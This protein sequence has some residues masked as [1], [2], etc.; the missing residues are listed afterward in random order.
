MV[1]NDLIQD[2]VNKID[3]A[4][5]QLSEDLPDSSKVLLDEVLAGNLSNIESDSIYTLIPDLEVNKR[6]HFFTSKARL[7]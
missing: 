7:C 6:L 5:E 4:T 3:T 2:S 1:S